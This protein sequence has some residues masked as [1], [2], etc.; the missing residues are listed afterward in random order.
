MF[1]EQP[2]SFIPYQKEDLLKVKGYNGFISKEGVFYKVIKRGVVE[3]AHDRY[4][5]AFTDMVLNI[6]L[7]EEYDKLRKSNPNLQNL[8]FKDMFIN[9]LGYINYEKTGG[10]LIIGCPDPK[11]NK[12]YI[13]KQQM[14]TIYQLIKINK[15]Y[16][17]DIKGLFDHDRKCNDHELHRSR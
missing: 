8:S 9:V 6:D 2:I 1:D 16:M 15:D 14:D 17:D 4:V 7:Q 3:S 10:R 13:T 12:Q 5:E 11:I